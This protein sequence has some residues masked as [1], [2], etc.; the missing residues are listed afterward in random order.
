MLPAEVLLLQKIGDV[1]HSLEG[2]VPSSTWL[3]LQPCVATLTGHGNGCLLFLCVVVHSC[4]G[5]S[6]LIRARVLICGV[7]GWFRLF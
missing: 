6:I 4:V 2:D 3:V 7:L 5:L 1:L